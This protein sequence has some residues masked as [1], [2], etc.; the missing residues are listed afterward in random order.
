MTEPLV[1]VGGSVAGVNAAE[2]ARRAGWTGDICLLEAQAAAPY[3]RPPLS[4]QLLAGEWQPEQI[5][6]RPEAFWKEMEIYVRAGVH[7]DRLEQDED[8]LVTREGER[9]PFS[10]LVVATGCSARTLGT[11]SGATSLQPPNA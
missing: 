6:L 4:K 9:I 8:L 3:D 5:H 2:G 10:G 1:V 7:V 11:I